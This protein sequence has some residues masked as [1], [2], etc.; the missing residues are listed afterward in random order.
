[1]LALIND[2]IITASFTQRAQTS[3]VTSGELIIERPFRQASAL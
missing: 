2:P 1:M 3:Q